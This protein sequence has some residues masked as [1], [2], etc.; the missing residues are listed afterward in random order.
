MN[1][2]FRL[3]GVE[4]RAG[5]TTLLRGIDL[6]IPEG[7]FL[8][9]VGPNGAGKTTFLRLL[10]R[11]IAPCRGMVML[12]GRPLESYDRRELAR[13]VSYVPQGD[14]FA[15]EFTVRAFVELGRYPYLGPWASPTME[16]HEAVDWAME[17][18]EVSHL[19]DRRMGTLS[20]G[21]RQRTVIAAA[22]AQ[23]GRVL[24]LD[25]PTSSLDYRHQVKIL[26]LLGRM[27]ADLGYTLVVV[28]HDLNATA[29]RSDFVV[30][31][32]D[33]RVAFGGPPDRFLDAERLQSIYGNAF[34][35]VRRPSGT[36][37]LVVARSNERRGTE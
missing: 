11:L 22:L 23:G 5:K 25:E 18:T 32:K 16:D 19:A 17:T 34:D 28:T 9:V 24:L 27:H 12:E 10:D 4:V 33:G 36:A 3:E 2:I 1:P 20:G 7:M 8:T 31:L 15:S 21:E 35:L 6:E 30:A 26:D 37:P 14:V 29:G 13:M